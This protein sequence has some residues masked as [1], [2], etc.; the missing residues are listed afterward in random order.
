MNKL[1]AEDLL[2]P[3]FTVTDEPTA[4][5][6]ILSGK[7]ALMLTAAS[8]VANLMK[9]STTEDFHL[10]GLAPL[11][12]ADGSK[13]YYSF[14]STYVEGSFTA[15][16]PESTTG[17]RRINALKLLNYLFTPAGHMLTNYGVE[18]E[19]YDMVNGIPTLSDVM[20]KNPDGKPLDGML[21]AYA[22]LN[23]PMWY[24]ASL[25]D[26]RYALPEQN[27]SINAWA[28]SD[29]DMY[30]I[31]NTSIIPEYSDEYAKLWTDINTYMMEYRS[32]FII[33]AKAPE[34]FETEYLPTLEKMGMPRVM[35]ILQASYEWYNK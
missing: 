21:R 33:G 27:Q 19:T 7:S 22:M 4:H 11:T 26:Q 9:S 30:Q 6:A 13:A 28:E 15:F 2:D 31:Q 17:E 10:L 24:D 1:Y 12:K 35:E 32:Q 3:N 18:G 34:T 8:R 29:S 23:W 20:T 14:G 5:A 25:L 16:I